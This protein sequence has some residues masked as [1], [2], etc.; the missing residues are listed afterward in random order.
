MTSFREDEGLWL[1]AVV[2]WGL[3]WLVIAWTLWLR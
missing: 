2:A 1:F 3:L